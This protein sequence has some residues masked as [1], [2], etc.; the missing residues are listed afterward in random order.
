MTSLCWLE[1]VCSDFFC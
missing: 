1:T